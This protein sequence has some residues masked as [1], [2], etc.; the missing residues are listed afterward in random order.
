[1]IEKILKN[2]TSKNISED[3]CQKDWCISPMLGKIQQV[4]LRLNSKKCYD[5]V[6]RYAVAEDAVAIVG[7][8][9]PKYAFT[10][11]DIW[12]CA[13]TGCMGQVM[14]VSPGLTTINPEHAIE[15]DYVFITNPSK[16]NLTPCVKFLQADAKSYEKTILM[17]KG[18]SPIRPI[19]YHI[20]KILAAA[21][22]LAHP[23]LVKPEDLDLA[24][25]TIF[26][27]KGI[28]K[29]MTRLSFGPPEDIGVSLLEIHIPDDSVKQTFKDIKKLLN[30][31][32]YWDSTDG[33]LEASSGIIGQFAAL[34]IVNEHINKYSHT[35][36]VSIMIRGGFK[37]LL[38]AYLSVNPPIA[39][40]Y[41]DMCKI[42]QDVGHTEAYDILAHY[43]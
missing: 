27:T 2:Y 17:D 10:G 36:A 39:D 30:N 28:D 20:Q 21:S 40:F 9:F 25:A 37:N 35:G 15:L 41:T 38:E 18:I 12:G 19:T 4:K 1:M 42:L 22:V 8:D 7:R 14:E 3:A 31:H 11:L 16:K 34:P 26:E 13:N 33:N 32:K 43:K 23:K 29:D 24:K 5:Y 6:C